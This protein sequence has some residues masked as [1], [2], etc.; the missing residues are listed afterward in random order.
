[1]EGFSYTRVD[2]NLTQFQMTKSHSPK[3]RIVRF[4]IKKQKRK[5]RKIIKQ[6]SNSNTTKSYT[7]FETI[8]NIV[9]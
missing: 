6:I 3:A 8:H 5:L 7:Q 4:I 2:T 9:K 1:M